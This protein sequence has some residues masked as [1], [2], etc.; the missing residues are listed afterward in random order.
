MAFLNMNG[1]TFPINPL[2][3]GL[4]D[5]FV[6]ECQPNTVGVGVMQPVRVRVSVGV[7]QSVSQSVSQLVNILQLSA[8]S[9]VVVAPVVQGITNPV[10]QVVTNMVEV[11]VGEIVA[12]NSTLQ[13]FAANF[14]AVGVT[15]FAVAVANAQEASVLSSLA[16]EIGIFNDVTANID[17]LYRLTGG[18]STARIIAEKL[19]G[20]STQTVKQIAQKVNLTD[21]FLV[22]IN[23]GSQSLLNYLDKLSTSNPQASRQLLTGVQETTS[24]QLAMAC[25]R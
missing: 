25:V 16:T 14:G 7:N 19:R 4:F 18:S 3:D 23:Q 2:F 21:E 22:A 12:S 1:F 17:D 10:R 20:L 8:Q 5:N 11:P 15:T 6:S 13:E 9:V 24:R